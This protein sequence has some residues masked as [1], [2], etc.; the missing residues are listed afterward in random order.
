[1][2]HVTEGEQPATPAT[3]TRFE[4]W[5]EGVTGGYSA[6]TGDRGDAPAPPDPHQQRRSLVN[7]A[8]LVVAVVVV[9]TFGHFL[10][11]VA[12]I[13]V[14]AGVI[15]LHE[16]GH[17]T[18]AKVSGMKVT[19]F[20]LGFGPRLWSVRRGETE[21][22]IKAIP[23]GGYCRIVGMNNLEEVDP[24]DEP[25]TYRRASFPRRLAVAV[26]GSTVHFIL[27][28]VTVW[29]L[30]AFAHQKAEPTVGSLL[31]LATAS[32]AQTA[33]LRP[34]DRFVAYDGHPVRS[35][36][37]L[38]TY[39]QH[40][41]GKPITFVV[42]RGGQRLDV[43]VTPADAAALTDRTGA[44]L[45]TQHVGI[46]GVVPVTANYSLLA[47]VP[48]A[49]RTFWDDGV[50]ATFGA[51][52]S[53]FSPHGISSISHQVVSKP[54]STPAAEAGARPVSVIGIVQLA[55]QLPGWAAKAFL[56]FE[57]NAFVGVLNLF[58]ILPFDG[59]HVVIAVYERI[60]S[61]RGRR[62]QADVNKMVPYAMA[63][64]VVLAFV[65]VS[66]IYLDV[67]HPITLH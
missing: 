55:G 32:P 48:H 7:L 34:G 51:L 62:Y 39:I 14:I 50:V 46:I 19:E 63:M 8:A 54:G 27:A 20:F 31:P 5:R 67:A 4:R 64:M 47:S 26:A 24:A 21:Y 35:W 56:F 33:G 53:I 11:V 15:M 65:F 36:D 29:A 45:A 52:G 30:F 13:A 41:L 9:A 59:G 60:R 43:T 58:P 38:H 42:Q 22:G 40:H 17:F 61:R 10:S 3:R 28:L 1:V 18:A 37:T 2:T 23:A 66:T 57:A 16:L 25:R 44:A 12:A 6:P 49:V